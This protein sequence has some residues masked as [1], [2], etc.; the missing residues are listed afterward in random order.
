[1]RCVTYLWARGIREN[2]VYGDSG[3]FYSP[4]LTLVLCIPISCYSYH[5]FNYLLHFAVI[6]H[7]FV[8]CHGKCLCI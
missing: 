6:R 3:S 1:M 5:N 8:F 4:A 7:D 2:T